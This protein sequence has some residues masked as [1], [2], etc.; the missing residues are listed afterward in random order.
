MNKANKIFLLSASYDEYVGIQYD[1]ETEI[2]WHIEKY[3]AVIPMTSQEIKYT[4]TLINYHFICKRKLW[5]FSHGIGFE[6]ES[7]AVYIGQLIAES[8]YK[9]EKKE[10]EIDQAIVMDW[11]DFKNKIVHEV[12]KSDRMEEAHFWQV[13]YYLYYL[14]Q[15][16]IMG[17]QARLDYPKQHQFKMV[18]L[19][20]EDRAK[21]KL[22]LED[23]FH[24][25]QQTKPPEAVKISA[26]RACSYFEFCW[27]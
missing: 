16:G 2:L 25:V 5:L 4:G 17:F 27:V 7:D 24:I 15:K 12:K 23:I 8:S 14:E 18:Q 10:I 11:I 9:K 13:K 22:T 6:K 1:T 19:T 3:K 20:D 21:L 26:C